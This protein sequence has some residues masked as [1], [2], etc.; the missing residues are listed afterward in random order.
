MLTLAMLAA[1]TAAEA[2]SSSTTASV[3]VDG[4]YQVPFETNVLLWS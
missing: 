1:T 2:V 4:G 3:T